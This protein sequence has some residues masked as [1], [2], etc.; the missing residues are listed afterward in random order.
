MNKKKYIDLVNKEVDGIINEKERNQLHQY[1]EENPGAKNLYLEIIRT[2]NI[3]NRINDVNP[4][5]NL[6]KRILNGIDT[7]RYASEVKRKWGRFNISNW[8]TGL[9]PKFAYAFAAG[10]IIG[11]VMYFVFLTEKVQDYPM[12]NIN[13]YGTIGIP[14]NENV[15][16]LDQISLDIKDVSGTVGM[17]KFNNI[18]WFDIN[19]THSEQCKIEL[20]FDQKYISFNGYKPIDYTTVYVENE[21]DK[22]TIHMN[23]SGQFLLLFSQKS[24]EKTQIDLH[25]TSKTEAPFTYEFQLR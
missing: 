17:Y 14:D 18:T 19:M 11:L 4:S 22:V 7:N 9:N 15:S 6:K 12:N 13:F 25:I 16:P 20:N 5:P 24:T 1:L 21:K 23:K 8:I 10:M 3:R 2:I